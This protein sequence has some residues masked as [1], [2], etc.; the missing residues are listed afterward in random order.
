MKNDKPSFLDREQI[1]K[2]FQR[3]PLA[4]RSDKP[5]LPN[6]ITASKLLYPSM[7]IKWYECKN[8]VRMILETFISL[9]SKK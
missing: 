2:E 3:V 9:E 6:F 8:D 5:V 4:I 1:T 7:A